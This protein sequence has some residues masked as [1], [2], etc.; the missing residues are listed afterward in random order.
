MIGRINFLGTNGLI[1]EISEFDNLD[2]LART[3]THENFNLN[4]TS[5]G[6]WNMS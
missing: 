2:D 6:P 3:I 4:S 1:G 5:L